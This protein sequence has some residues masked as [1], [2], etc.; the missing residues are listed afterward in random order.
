MKEIVQLKKCFHDRNIRTWLFATI[1][2][3]ALRRNIFFSIK[4]SINCETT[5]FFLKIALKSL[6]KLNKTRLTFL[7]V[8]KLMSIMTITTTMKSQA[9]TTMKSNRKQTIS[10]IT[11]KHSQKNVASI[12]TRCETT[13]KKFQHLA[14]F[15]IALQ[16]VV[17]KLRNC[18]TSFF[19]KTTK[20]YNWKYNFWKVAMSSQNIAKDIMMITIVSKTKIIVVILSMLLNLRSSSSKLLLIIQISWIELLIANVTLNSSNLKIFES[21]KRKSIKLLRYLRR[22]SVKND[23][24]I[25]IFCESQKFLNLI[26]THLLKVSKRS[27]AIR[28]CAF[29]SA[30]S[31]WKK[32]DNVKRSLFLILFSIWIAF[33]WI[34]IILFLMRKNFAR[35]VAKFSNL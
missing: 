10:I 22:T 2:T 29:T 15:Q 23:I 8:I 30:K 19:K 17:A 27:L 25:K 6:K 28:K 11:T 3:L 1:T 14:M 24:N 4:Q 21:K 32:Q 33:T 18:E 16:K 7:T 35:C 34:W 26:D 5:W 20:R 9:I 12:L 13:W 31:N